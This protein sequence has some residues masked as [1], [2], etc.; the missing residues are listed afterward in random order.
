VILLDALGDY[1]QADTINDIYKTL[2]TQWDPIRHRAYHWVLRG[3]V[4][5]HRGDSRAAIQSAEQALSIIE[6][7]VDHR[8]Q[9]WLPWMRVSALIVQA[10]AHAARGDLDAALDDYREGLSIKIIAGARAVTNDARGGVARVAMQQ[11]D[12]EIAKTQ[13]E[14][15]L[16]FLE[17]RALYGA[18]EPLRIRLTCYRVLDAAGDPRAGG[19]LETAH[20]LL[21]ERAEGIEDEALR[22]SYLDNVRAHQEIRR[23]WAARPI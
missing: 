5:Y 18:M 13:V 15:I 14:A 1:Q 8:Q 20:T 21:M 19:V 23:L 12:L 17:S 22:L 6:G 9:G 16:G 11:G 4:A 10:H 3:L 7:A 2:E